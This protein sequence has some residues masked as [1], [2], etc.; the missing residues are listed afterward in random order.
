MSLTDRYDHVRPSPK[1]PTINGMKITGFQKQT[2]SPNNLVKLEKSDCSA[3]SQCNMLKQDP[4]PQ[5]TVDMI[6]QQ[7][8]STLASKSWADAEEFVPGKMWKTSS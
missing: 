2:E 4:S 5:Q 3:V 7:L 8:S 1:Q 6:G